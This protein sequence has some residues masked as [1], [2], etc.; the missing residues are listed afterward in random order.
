MDDELRLRLKQYD[1][2]REEILNSISWQNRLL[3]SG[4]AIV[5]VI[6][7][8]GISLEQWRMLLIA[9][10]PVVILF[11]ALWLVEQSRMMR[12][13]DYLQMLENETNLYKGGRSYLSWENWLRRKWAGFLNIHRIHHWAQYVA[14]LCLYGLSILGMFITWTNWASITGLK[15]ETINGVV[16][17]VAKGLSCSYYWAMTILYGALLVLIGLLAAKAVKHRPMDWKDFT[18]WEKDY[19]K[20]IKPDLTKEPSHEAADGQGKGKA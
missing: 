14:I 15:T 10:P 4:M 3:I 18:T 19:E 2:L 12:A 17:T 6:F 1:L 13:G 7:A 5:P 11:T 9:L 20:L 8:L 16:V